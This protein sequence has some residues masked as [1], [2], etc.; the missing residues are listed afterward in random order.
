MKEKMYVPFG[1]KDGVA[2][3]FHSI[4]KSRS[5]SSCFLPDIYLENIDVGIY[6][7]LLIFLA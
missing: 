6:F 3:F 4:I 1:S 7:E 2:K 5:I